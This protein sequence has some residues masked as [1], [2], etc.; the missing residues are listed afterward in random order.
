MIRKTD[1]FWWSTANFLLWFICNLDRNKSVQTT[2]MKST[3]YFISIEESSSKHFKT[4]NFHVN[5]LTKSEWTSHKNVKSL[6]PNSRTCKAQQ[7]WNDKF[8]DNKPSHSH[9]FTRQTLTKPCTGVIFNI[10]HSTVV[11]VCVCQL[12]IHTQCDS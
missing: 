4:V 10:T 5:D 7:C 8:T 11:C 6:M 3:T 12:N 1:S 2:N 9:S